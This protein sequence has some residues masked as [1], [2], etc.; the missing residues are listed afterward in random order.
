MKSDETAP[1]RTPPSTVREGEPT[2]ANPTMPPEP[3][4]P[5]KING[6]T[7]RGKLG[8]G[9]MGAVFLAE[10]DALGRNVAIKV[11]SNAGTD[12][13]A[14]ARFLREARSMATAEHPN[15]VRVLAFGT[16]DA[17]PYLIMELVDG[18]SLSKRIERVKK[19]NVSDALRIGRQ[20]VEALAASWQKGI[21]HRDIKPSNILIDKK[22]TVRVADFGLAKPA[23]AAGG[24]ELTA[25]GLM[26]G[27][28]FYVAPEQAAAM[29]TDFRAD[30]YS[31]GIVLY[32]MLIGERP[33]TGR[34]AVSVVAKHLHEPLPSLQGKVP[35]T[36]ATLIERM[37]AKNPQARYAS[38]ALLLR[39]IDRIAS[40]TTATAAAM[41]AA[42]AAAVVQCGDRSQSRG[43]C[44][45]RS[46]LLS[47]RHCWP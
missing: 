34:N 44:G 12:S 6:Y 17:K 47:S 31:L 39:D 40:E 43:H 23:V 33:F 14:E 26:V 18:E 5:P 16:V 32:E 38:Y 4:A 11:I 25:T 3:V 28:P 22:G 24:D 46:Q 1:Y 30:I 9:G 2:Y 7:I 21:V 15:I 29:A 8:E 37:T 19:F 10:D 41:P 36:V 13:L 20:V 42:S 45:W 27:S 35:P